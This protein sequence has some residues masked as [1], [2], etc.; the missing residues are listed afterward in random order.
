MNLNNSPT[1]EQLRDLIAAADDNEC[2]HQIWV[3]KNGEVHLQKSTDL[4]WN[5]RQMDRIDYEQFRLETFDQGNGYVG[6]S[7]AK[8]EKW[9]SDLFRGLQMAWQKNATG[10][11]D[12]WANAC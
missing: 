5:D 2:S 8:D 1:I 10:Y 12:D 4:R 3:G 7:A 6:K 11:V 9:I